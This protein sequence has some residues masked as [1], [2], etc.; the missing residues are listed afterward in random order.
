[1]VSAVN[2]YVI[3]TGRTEWEAAERI[4]S[5]N[6]SPLTPEGERTAGCVATE[7]TAEGIR[8]VYAAEA[9]AEQQTAKIIAKALRAK[10]HRSAGLR[11]LDFGL[12]QGLTHAEIRRRQPKLYRLWT[13]S[14]GEVVPPGGEP[15]AEAA[16]RLTGAL[17][18]IAKKQKGAPAAV[19]VR[20]M[21]AEIL[22]RI[23]NGGQPTGPGP[24]P[25]ACWGCF[26]LADTPTS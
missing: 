19:V 9:D 17:K 14:P 20:P 18:A 24:G 21:I 2:I 23:L 7:L 10:V 8:A 11:D 1:M 4:E 12:W 15:T 26:K 22:R 25:E 6:G 3:Q 13:E 5:A 16:D